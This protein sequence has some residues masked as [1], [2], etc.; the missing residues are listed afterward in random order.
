VKLLLLLS[1]A[2]LLLLLRNDTPSSE[3]LSAEL[4]GVPLSA[5]L[6]L[7][8]GVRLEVLSLLHLL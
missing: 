5:R 3:S 2:L 7:L 6:V 8:L 1:I 4:G